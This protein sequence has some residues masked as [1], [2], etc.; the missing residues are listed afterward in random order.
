M[1]TGILEDIAFGRMGDNI[2]RWILLD[3]LVFTRE[4]GTVSGSHRVRVIEG[5][6]TYSLVRSS[7]S[8]Y[9]GVAQT[10]RSQIINEPDRLSVERKIAVSK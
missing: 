4:L 1:I 9:N 8:H 5:N 10:R 2:G 7:G 6:G 3:G